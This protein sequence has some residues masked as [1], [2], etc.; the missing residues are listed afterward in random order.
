MILDN[1][2]G[3][4]GGAGKLHVGTRNIFKFCK[5]ASNSAG[6]DGGSFSVLDYSLLS[7]AACSFDGD[8]AGDHGG[9]I[10]AHEECRV[11]VNRVNI[12]DSTA[13]KNGGAI[14]VHASKA[15]FNKTNMKNCTSEG[16]GTSFSSFASRVYVQGVLYT[17]PPEST[18]F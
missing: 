3:V 5:F 6:H 12:T 13:G 18:G 17:T 15:F 2:A 7:V 10:S 11:I 4:H 8:S 1:S 14:S 16:P 9:S